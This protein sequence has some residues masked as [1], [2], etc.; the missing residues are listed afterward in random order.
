MILKDTMIVKCQ[1]TST[2][3]TSLKSLANM[4]PTKTIFNLFSIQLVTYIFLSKISVS[5]LVLL[6]L[7]FYT[8]RKKFFYHINFYWASNHINY[9]RKIYFAVEFQNLKDINLYHSKVWFYVMIEDLNKIS[10][11]RKWEFISFSYVC[12]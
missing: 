12:H 4:G 1:L 3:K 11:W 2:L 5:L 7:Y 9:S 8:H 10:L 6:Y